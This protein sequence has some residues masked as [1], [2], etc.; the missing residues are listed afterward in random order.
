MF[1]WILKYT[2]GFLIKLIWV[3]KVCGLENIPKNGPVI[4][5]ANHSS[6]FDFLTIAS[7]C[8]RGVYFLAGEVFFEKWQWRWLMKLTKQIKVDRRIKDKSDSVNNVFDYLKKGRMVGI[9]P[10]GTRSADG[11]IH[12]FYN[13]AVRIALESDAP[14]IPVGISGTYEIMSRYDKFPRFNKKCVLNFGKKIY[15]EDGRINLLSKRLKSYIIKL[16]N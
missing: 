9:F 1:Y 11:K 14:I 10:E 12:N 7:V 4:L 2:L 6:Y 13:G 8:P 5:C 15:F 3:E 16:L